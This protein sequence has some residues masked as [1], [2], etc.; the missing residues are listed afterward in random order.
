MPPSESAPTSALCACA[1][2]CSPNT[3]SMPV[4]MPIGSSHW[5]TALLVSAS[6][7]RG[8]AAMR[9]AIANVSS[10]SSA[11]GDDPVDHAPLVRPLG[12]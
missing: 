10:S 6:P 1:K 12:A 2:W 7:K 5:L 11:R 8:I 9:S 3:E 4:R